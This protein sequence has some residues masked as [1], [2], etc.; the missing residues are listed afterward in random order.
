MHQSQ[1][2]KN[3]CTATAQSRDL[4]YR[5]LKTNS[6]LLG[7]SNPRKFVQEEKCWLRGVGIFRNRWPRNDGNIAHATLPRTSFGYYPNA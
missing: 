5:G 6:K 4:N 1:S 2:A 7:E 3:V